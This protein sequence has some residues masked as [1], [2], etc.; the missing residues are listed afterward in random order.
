VRRPSNRIDFIFVTVL[1]AVLTAC[2][3]QPTETAKAATTA[4]NLSSE[5]L[6]GRAIQRRAVEAVIWSTPAVN[7]DRMYRAMVHDAKSGEGNNKIVYW[8]NLFD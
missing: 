5:D 7:F 8:S 6:A 3:N 4:Q 2:Q 1:L